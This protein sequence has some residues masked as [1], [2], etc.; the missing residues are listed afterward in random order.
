MDMHD[1]DWRESYRLVDEA[2]GAKGRAEN[3]RRNSPGKED[4]ESVMDWD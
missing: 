4:E 3:E 2:N 1:T